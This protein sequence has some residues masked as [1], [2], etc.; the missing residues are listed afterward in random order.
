MVKFPQILFLDEPTSGLDSAAS[1]NVVKSLKTIAKKHNIII[2]MTIHQPNTSTYEL[3][4]NLF[5]LS[6][7]NP[8]Y[9]GKREKLPPFLNDIGIPVG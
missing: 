8:I 3:I 6:R 4:D 7:G 1:Y 2:V 9:F 5:V